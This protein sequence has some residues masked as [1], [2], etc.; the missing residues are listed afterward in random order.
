MRLTEKQLKK[1]LGITQKEIAGFLTLL[2]QLEIDDK[3]QCP[4]GII[5]KVKRN[6]FTYETND[7]VISEISKK[8]ALEHDDDLLDIG[9][10]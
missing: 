10:E 3:F 4:V 9:T 1:T 5:H 2:M 7:E 8:V 6:T